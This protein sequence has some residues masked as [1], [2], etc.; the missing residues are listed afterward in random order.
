[1]DIDVS[2][3]IIRRIEFSLLVDAK[4]AWLEKEDVDAANQCLIVRT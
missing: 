4:G 2:I 1:M 3:D